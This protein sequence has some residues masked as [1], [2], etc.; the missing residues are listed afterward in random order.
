MKNT[1][2]RIVD[3]IKQNKIDYGHIQNNKKNI[4]TLMVAKKEIE[5]TLQKKEKDAAS[6]K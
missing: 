4:Q 5:E 6:N 2:N 1:F 3:V